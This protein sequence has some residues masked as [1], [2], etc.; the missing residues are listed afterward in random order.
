MPLLFSPYYI[1]I[2][3]ENL[4]SDILHLDFI[5]YMP[6]SIKRNKMEYPERQF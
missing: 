3:T 2:I 4:I 5:V 1:N 6:Y